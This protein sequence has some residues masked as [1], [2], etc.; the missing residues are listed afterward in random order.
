M[1]LPKV[2]KA[3]SEILDEMHVHDKELQLET[4]KRV[5]KMYKELTNG[6]EIDEKTILKKTF[7]IKSNDIVLV[8][9]IFFSSLCEHHL[10]PFFGE[11]NIAYIPNGKIVGLSKLGRL[12]DILAHRLQLQERLT[13]QIGETIFEQLQPYGVIVTCKAQHTC[14]ICRGVKKYG[15]LTTTFYK[16][17]E[18]SEQQVNMLLGM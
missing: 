16:K 5:A 13:K 7:P 15:S 12:V 17:G 6:Q 18:I 4:P 1:N 9:D 11:I 3:I 2:E 10:M 8:K 14:M